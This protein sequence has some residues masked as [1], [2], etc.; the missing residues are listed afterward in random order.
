MGTRQ[1]IGISVANC[2]SVMAKGSLPVTRR[3]GGA[4][5]AARFTNN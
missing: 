2:V 3:G 1:T 5:G 4:T